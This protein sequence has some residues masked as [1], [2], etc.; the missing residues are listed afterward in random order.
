M[1]DIYVFKINKTLSLYENMRD[2]LKI[3]ISSYIRWYI[4]LRGVSMSILPLCEA[5]FNLFLNNVYVL[6][7]VL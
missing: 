7:V 5:S 6:L 4:L 3:L 1:L 2:Y